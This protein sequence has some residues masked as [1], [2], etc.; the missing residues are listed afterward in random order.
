MVLAI[1]LLAILCV[2]FLFDLLLEVVAERRGA[3]PASK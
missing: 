3:N 2:V 1:P